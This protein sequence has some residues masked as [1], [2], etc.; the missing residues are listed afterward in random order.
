MSIN[1]IQASVIIKEIETD[2]HSPLLII[3]NDFKKYVA[4]NGKGQ[5]PPVAIINECLG[6]HFLNCWQILTPYFSLVRFNQDLI[7]AGNY[8]S[9]H[10]PWFYDSW[11]FGSEYLENVIEVN[12]FTFNQSKR[13]YNRFLNPRDFFR[14]ALFDTWLEN[15]DRKPSNYNLL[16]QIIDNQYKI[17]PIDQ[18][19]IFSTMDYENLNPDLFSPSYNEHI[20]VSELAYLL[21]KNTQINDDFISQEKQ[22]FYFCVQKCA[23]TVDNFIAELSNFIELTSENVNKIKDFLFH[24]KRNK[25]VFEEFIF[26]LKQ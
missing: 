26:R 18:A 6:N 22:Y 4:K 25:K 15:D 10:R 5:N 11:T 2:G 3:G 19:Y 1:S 23:E 24:K 8:S 21:K 7:R 12:E 9:M 16:F 14:I 20:L 13:T 17:I